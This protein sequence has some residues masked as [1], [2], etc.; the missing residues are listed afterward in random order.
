MLDDAV[1]EYTRGELLREV[2]LKYLQ[3]SRVL[4]WPGVDGFTQ[5]DILNFYPFAS[6]L[7]EVPPWPE[8]CR[9]HA[10]LAGEIQSFFKS[11]GWHDPSAR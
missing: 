8:L 10:E 6:A 3:G 1:N 9:Q 7:G 4:D 11:K 2:L 5:D